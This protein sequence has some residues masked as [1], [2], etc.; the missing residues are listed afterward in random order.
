MIYVR[1]LDDPEFVVV[2]GSE[3]AA[4]V[5]LSYDGEWLAFYVPTRGVSKLPVAGGTPAFVA[6][7]SD[8]GWGETGDLV[9]RTPG[10]LVLAPADGSSPRL[11]LR[12]TTLETDATL[13]PGGRDVLASRGSGGGSALVL[14][15]IADGHVTDLHM[16]GFGGR[17]A[18]GRVIFARPLGLVYS[19]PFSL[20]KRAFTGPATLLLE[21]V[22]TTG[23]DPRKIELAV[24]G[25]GT[26]VYMTG[27]AAV[28]SMVTVDRQ[29]VEQPLSREERPYGEPRVS[30]DGKR[31][32]VRIGE[33]STAGDVWIYDMG[34]GSLTPLTT[35]KK[36]MRPE[37]S[38]DG[39]RIITT[40]NLSPDSILVQ[41][42]PWDG[43]GGVETLQRGVGFA[44]YRWVVTASIG[45]PHGWSAFRVKTAPFADIFI[46][47]TDSLQ[48]LRPFV[49]TPAIELMPRVAPSGRLLAYSSNKSG[50]TEVYLRPIPGPG[51]EVTVS[52]SGGSEPIWSSDGTSLFYRGPTRMM[53]ATVV[54]RP[55]PAVAKRDSLFIDRW[56]RS[57]EHGGYDVFPDG[58]HFVMTRPA[59]TA[60]EKPPSLFVVLNWPQL[61]GKQSGAISGR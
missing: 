56:D 19:A 46:A 58:K 15:S 7:G 20:S 11:L 60:T 53:V 54:E 29:G 10:G 5:S 13:L 6:T 31:V 57:L 52:T 3:G 55:A 4:S 34:A 39:T 22:R 18:E 17:Y 35:D 42:R 26:L 37:W 16:A 51:P 9:V 28:R 59:K 25:N 45:P 38:R 40:D 47:P 30:P 61:L 36:S 12:D 14:V 43:S 8:P 27:S 48:A 32:V 41:S 33:S 49:A 23:A 2:R 21:D 1:S 44:K 50:R 24:A